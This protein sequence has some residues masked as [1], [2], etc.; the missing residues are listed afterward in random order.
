MKS[1]DL[2]D[3]LRCPLGNFSVDDEPA[4]KL[5]GVVEGILCV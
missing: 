1:L 3:F 2:A 4:N 5:A